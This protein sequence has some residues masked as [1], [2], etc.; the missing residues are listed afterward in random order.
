MS[1]PDWVQDA[2]FYQIFPD[3]FANGD[4]ANDPEYVKPWGSPPTLH[5]FQGGDLRGIRDHIDYLNDLGINAIYLNPIF[6]S[7]STHRYDTVDYFR[8]DPRLGDER[9]FLELLNIAHARNIR[10]I[11][12]GVFNHCGRGF[13]AFSDILENGDQSPYQHW[14]HIKKYPVNAYGHGDAVDYLA[15]WNF[16]NLPK[17]NTSNKETRDY[18]M[19]VVR[20]WTERGIDGWRL[21]VP[22]EINDDSF[23][24]EFSD[25]VRG[26]NQQAYTVGEIWDLQPRW[27]GDH[28]FNGVMHYPLRGA[29]IELLNH[30]I[31]VNEFGSK[32]SFFL[33]VYPKENLNSLYLLLGSHDTERI[34]TMLG[35]NISKVKLAYLLLFTYPGVPSIYY[36]D[37]IGMEGGKDPDCR[38]AF[39]WDE[40]RWNKGLHTWV[41]KLIQIRKQEAALRMG[42]CTVI[43]GA[44]PD[45]VY[46]AVRN[47]EG[48]TLITIINPNAI[49]WDGFLPVSETGWG[50]GDLLEDILGSKKFRVEGDG[51]NL[52]IPAYQGLLIKRIGMGESHG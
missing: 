5:G 50:N 15:W 45:T 13:F 9:E 2:V 18:L 1:V 25:L 33:Q 37:E 47:H 21:D 46:S 30:K 10:I 36:G 19:Q 23:W 26:I 16:K 39:P 27:V 31:T 52:Q 41:R 8:I 38:R 51:L 6:Q 42:T 7:P 24:A 22:N 28:H 3:R 32:V 40:S 12:D 43:R 44:H 14:F 49:T 20:Y 34:M 35:G 4:P 48:E 17:L 11:L 29:L